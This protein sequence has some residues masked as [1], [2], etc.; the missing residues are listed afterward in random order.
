MAAINLYCPEPCALQYDT[1]KSYSTFKSFLV[2][3]ASSGIVCAL[4]VEIVSIFI[5]CHNRYS[6]FNEI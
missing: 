4:I 6:T 3:T 2:Y 5:I 1:S